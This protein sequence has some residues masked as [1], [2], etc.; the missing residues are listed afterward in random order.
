MGEISIRF[1][2]ALAIFSLVAILGISLSDTYF[3]FWD[4]VQLGSKHAHWFYENR[5]STLFLPQEFDSGHI[6]AFGMYLAILWLIFGKSLLVSHWAMLPFL[7]GLIWQGLLWSKKIKADR[8]YFLV[9][10]VLFLNPVILSQATLVSPDV[11]LLFFFMLG[12]NAIYDQKDTYLLIA[13]IGLVLVSIRGMALAGSLF[14]LFH[15]LNSSKKKD[16]RQFKKSILVFLPAFLILATY[17]ILHYYHSGWIG[18][19]EAS[20]W[21]ESFQ[22]RKFKGIVSNTGI[23]SWRLLDFG[24][25]FIHLIGGVLIFQ[26]WNNLKSDLFF[27]KLL[28]TTLITALPLLTIMIWAEGLNAHRYLLPLDI[29]LFSIDLYV[30]FTYLLNKRKRIFLLTIVILG[31]ISGNFWIYPDHIAQ[32]WDASLAH[33][34]Y[35]ELR[36]EAMQYLNKKDIPFSEIGSSF[37]NIGPMKYIDLSN[38][39]SGFSPYDLNRQ[40]YI[41]YSNIYNDF[42][43]KDIQQLKNSW[44]VEKEWSSR[45]V[46]IIL[47][48]KSI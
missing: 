34:P 33:R 42:T 20:P 36:K 18:V 6:P 37:P 7:I 48:R 31:L 40:N 24:K 3:F 22:A 15:F 11:V 32:G 17:M 10:L 8:N 25:I 29:L 2:V 44:I 46:K 16:L 35:Y 39:N 30:I 9:L 21:A 47:Y 5:F 38:E 13:A 41:L 26:H 23:I 45:G 43:D 28:K 27:I 4:T 19:H 1:F 14:L 12:L